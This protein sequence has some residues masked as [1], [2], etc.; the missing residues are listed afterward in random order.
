MSLCVDKR[1]SSHRVHSLVAEAFIG[2][3]PPGLIVCHKD[4]NPKNNNVD[5]LY[6]GTTKQ[7]SAD[8]IRHGTV[9]SGER[10]GNSK[11]T[12]NQVRAMRSDGRSL[13]EI[14]SDIG[15]SISTVSRAIKRK[16]WS[17]L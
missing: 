17:Y 12:E 14:A 1:P 5:N 2:P 10:N 4:G 13:T 6:Y 7:N 11:L 9:A 8:S 16:T 3:R 15:V